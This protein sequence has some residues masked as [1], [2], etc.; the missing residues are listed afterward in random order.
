MKAKQKKIV[1]K[2]YENYITDVYRS[3]L[4]KNPSQVIDTNRLRF[5]LLS[6]KILL[7]IH[8]N[9]EIEKEYR[10]ILLPAICCYTK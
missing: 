4:K 7:A 2:Y 6:K 10:T 3:R 8:C 5:L 1:E 9:Y